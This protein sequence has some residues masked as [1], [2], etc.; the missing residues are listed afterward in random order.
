G[1]LALCAAN[2][3]GKWSDLEKRVNENGS[4]RA[5]QPAE[6]RALALDAGIAAATYDDSIRNYCPKRL[7]LE[8]AALL[9][10]GVDAAP[11]LIIG[12]ELVRGAVSQDV[13]DAAIAR[14]MPK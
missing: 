3:A 10:R 6:L 5:N 8:H 9:A 14:A 1:A 12:S 11:T 4:K 7:A 13:Y 2:R